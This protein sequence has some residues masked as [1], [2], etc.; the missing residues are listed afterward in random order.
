MEI[1]S[2]QVPQMSKVSGSNNANAKGDVHKNTPTAAEIQA[3]I[4]SYLAELLEIDPDEVETT[5]P[6]DRYGLDSSAVVAITGEI[7]E[8][9]GCEVDPTLLYDY[10]TIKAVAHQ[11]AEEFKIKG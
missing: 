5:I 8:R 11:L 6:F 10:P 4:I 3:W 2:P 7:E 1:P 9:F